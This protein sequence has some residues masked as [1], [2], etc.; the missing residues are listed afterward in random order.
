MSQ[1]V[2]L[3]SET[4]QKRI[5]EPHKSVDGHHVDFSIEDAYKVV[6]VLLEIIYVVNN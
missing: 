6:V 3:E 4:S 1:L 2:I 5:I